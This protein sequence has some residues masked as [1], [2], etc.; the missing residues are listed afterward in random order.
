MA[1]L[2]CQCYVCTR[3]ETVSSF[4]VPFTCKSARMY[5]SCHVTQNA[6]NTCGQAHD[7]QVG[8]IPQAVLPVHVCRRTSAIPNYF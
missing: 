5:S 3:L 6:G 2:T 8:N 1:G 7:D 4:W